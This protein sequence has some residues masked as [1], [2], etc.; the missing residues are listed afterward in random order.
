MAHGHRNQKSLIVLQL[1]SENQKYS[2][3]QGPSVEDAGLVGE[4]STDD[5]AEFATRLT[6]SGSGLFLS[7]TWKCVMEQYLEKLEKRET[8]DVHVYKRFAQ[9]PFYMHINPSLVYVD[10]MIISYHHIGFT[11]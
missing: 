11:G 5:V 6:I 7:N 3:F 10:I 1:I 2:N 4:R 9:H 8:G